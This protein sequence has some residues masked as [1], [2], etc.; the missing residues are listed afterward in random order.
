MGCLPGALVQDWVRREKI[1]YLP[2]PKYITSGNHEFK[3]IKYR[4]MVMQK[5]GTDIEKHFRTH[6][7][8]CDSTVCYLALRIVSSLTTTPPT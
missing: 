6:T 7:K 2:V 8:F 1:P 4:F 3:G 5:F